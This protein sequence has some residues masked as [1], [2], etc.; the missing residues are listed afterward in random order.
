[1]GKNYIIPIA[2]ILTAGFL[3][4]SLVQKNSAAS[5]PEL[6]L[7]WQALNYAPPG[8][9]GKNLPIRNSPVEAALTII[10]NGKPAN[11]SNQEIRWFV[12]RN[13][14]QSGI[15]LTRFPFAVPRLASS[16]VPLKV[17]VI[18]YK[19]A[20][21]EKSVLVPVAKP[22]TIITT[23]AADKK[24]IAGINLIEALAYFFNVKNINQ[25]LFTWSANNEETNGASDTPNFLELDAS[26][27]GPGAEVKLSV[28]V[29]NKND[30]LEGA[31]DETIL[32]VK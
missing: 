27:G 1:M 7:T 31:K 32:I 4:F 16:G 12:D 5:E 21:L 11:L 10:E 18:N 13:L 15:G 17:S 22:E 26:Q 23:G 3:F 19:G 29:V 8:Y 24:I 20:D 2:A 25:L 30:A 9:Q 14:E 6:M 28:S